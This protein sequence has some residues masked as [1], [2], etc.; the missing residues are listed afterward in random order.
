MKRASLLVVL[1]LLVASPVMAGITRPISICPRRV[2]SDPAVRLKSCLDGDHGRDRFPTFCLETGD[3][4][5]FRELYRDHRW[6]CRQ[7]RIV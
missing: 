7:E 3:T 6:R 1:A 4:S 5:I 2:E